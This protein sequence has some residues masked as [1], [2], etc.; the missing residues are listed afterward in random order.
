M[1][2]RFFCV[3]VGCLF[4]VSA[5]GCIAMLAGA[6][7]GGAGTAVWLS[8]K[9]TQVYNVPYEKAVKASER[10]LAALKLKI[11]KETSEAQVTQ[12][13]SEYTDGK[14]IW[15]DIKKVTDYSSKVE[16]RVGGVSYDK[17]AAAKILKKIE[18]YL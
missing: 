16:V 3:V 14:D 11:I 17:D 15:I 8:G 13:K 5:C 2:K 9:L 10:A 4:L 1:V 7:A 6:A 18:R 12:L